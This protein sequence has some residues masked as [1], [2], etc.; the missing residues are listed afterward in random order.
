MLGRATLRS[1]RLKIVTTLGGLLVLA[2]VALSPVLLLGIVGVARR[3]D[4]EELSFVGQTYGAIAAVVTALSV[5]AVGVSLLLQVRALN[6]QIEQA[7]R[8]HYFDLLAMGLQYPDALPGGPF[9][10]SVTSAMLYSGLWIS[11]WRTLFMLGY[12]PEAEL[13]IE[14]HAL[15]SASSDARDRWAF[16]KEAYL[17]GALGSKGRQFFE[18][19]E[20]QHNLITQELRLRAEAAK[21]DE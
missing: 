10:G 19:V 16:G 6:V 18:L 14:I 3:Q 7:A 17:S 8:T 9:G 20:S 12:M 2:V 4:W 21:S 13:R 15:F 11:Y 5:L 1:R